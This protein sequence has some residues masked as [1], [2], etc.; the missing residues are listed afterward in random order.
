MKSTLATGVLL[1]GVACAAAA[2][3]R[4]HTVHS[5]QAFSTQNPDFG[6]QPGKVAIDGDFAIVIEDHETQRTAALYRRLT[7]GSWE[8]AGTLLTVDSPG[9]MA[10]NDD[11]AMADGI[12]AIRIGGV[13]RIFE[14]SGSGYT[15]SAT[16]GTP[17]GAPGL[18]ISNRRIASARRGCNYDAAV[19][20]KSST[21]VWNI[22]GRI[23]GAAGECNNHGALLDLDGDVALVR[24]SP[25]EIREYRRNGTAIVWPQVSTI[26]APPNVSFDFQAPSLSGDTAFVADGHYFRRTGSTWTYQ[27]QLEPLDSAT[28]TF[29]LGAAIRDGKVLSPTT[30]DEAHPRSDPYVYVRN[31][32]GGYDHVAV[33]S[34]LGG[35][36]G[37]GY[38]DVSGNRAIVASTEEF[39]GTIYLQFFDLPTPLVAPA[40]IA[41]DFEERDVSG[42]QQTAGSQFGLADAATGVVYRQSSVVDKSTATLSASDWPNAQSIEAEI[43]PTAFACADCWVGLTARYI[44]ADNHYY[45]T[46]RDSNTIELKRMVNGVFSTLRSL[47]MPVTPNARYRVKLIV[48]GSQLTVQVDGG[49]RLFAVDTA[50]AHGRAGLMTYRARAD[51]DNVYVG[52]TAPFN[53]ARK[54]FSGFENGRDFTYQGGTWE[55]IDQPGLPEDVAFG[56]TSTAGDARAFV[57]TTLKDQE[58]RARMRLESY[59][60]SPNGAWFGLL[61]RFIDA[62][63]HY[64]LSLRG[65][66]RLEIRRQLNGVS[67]LLR[68]VP[69]TA[70]PGRYYDVRF[71][72]VGNELHTY[73]DGTFLAGAIDN[74]IARGQYGIATVRAAATWQNF[75]VDQ[76]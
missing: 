49:F 25:T 46:L 57:G 35:A 32:A 55:L 31:A 47:A 7:T 4:V 27:R 66:N 62:R 42:W 17:T 43:T 1:L 39:D 67:T 18:A 58:I 61:A 70:T 36:G 65:S 48:N 9:T 37:Q 33:L 64:S 24:N 8:K 38:T 71:V 11:L 22:T 63:N 41:N 56:Q 72:V 30:F 26:A 12:A 6:L 68:S 60:A 29:I 44:D 73:V 40:A 14:R 13:L 75:F 74:V 54:D 23:S 16:A 19:H 2:Q 20:Q 3:T 21:G 69:F 59:G 76:P 5:V 52:S 28:G 10:F 53:V 45:V 34:A 50:L 51:F 15:E